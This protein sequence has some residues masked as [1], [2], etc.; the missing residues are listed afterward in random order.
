MLDEN[1]GGQIIRKYWKGLYNSA[2]EV[3]VDIRTLESALHIF[4]LAFP[5]LLL[6]ELSPVMLTI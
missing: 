3:T 2:D 4:C 1:Q 6:T 5:S